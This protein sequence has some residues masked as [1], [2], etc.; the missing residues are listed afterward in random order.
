MINRLT[1]AI[2][3]RLTPAM[4]IIV[5]GAL[6]DLPQPAQAR[7]WFGFPFYF[8]LPA[9]VPASGLLPPAGLLPTAI[10]LL[11]AALL[12]AAGLCA[13]AGGL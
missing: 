12:S 10:R 4:V 13:S 8:G 5:L 3:W 11:P 7:V 9:Y 6:T 1:N 2:R